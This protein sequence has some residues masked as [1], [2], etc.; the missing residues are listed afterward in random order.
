MSEEPSME[1]LAE[2]ERQTKERIG[3]TGKGLQPAG[4]NAPWLQELIDNPPPQPDPKDAAE[5]ERI[6]RA[7]EV[8]RLRSRLPRYLAVSSAPD[9]M[10]R[11]SDERLLKAAKLW[12]P[13]HGNAVLLGETGLGKSTAAAVI[14]RRL[15]RGGVESG[16]R[17]WELAQ[18]IHWVR[19]KQLERAV[20]DHPRGKGMC[21]ALRDAFA[22]PLLVLDEAGWEGDP[23]IVSDVLAERYDS[24]RL[25]VLTSGLTLEGFRDDDD[26]WNPGLREK[27]GDAVIRRM[28]TTLG[29]GAGIVEAFPSMEAAEEQE[30][31]SR[32][33]DPVGAP[34]N[35]KPPTEVD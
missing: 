6:E 9:L 23:T 34:R 21:P 35:P 13:R 10:A 20:N 31:R 33:I 15:I 29:R 22:A 2:I 5:A 14:C 19:A 30:N 28:I 25:T 3:A 16:G 24:P 17:M 12:H 26:N 4:I 7:N 32:R 11:I 27:Y 1:D 8:N 18:G